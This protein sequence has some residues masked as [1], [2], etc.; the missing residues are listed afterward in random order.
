MDYEELKDGP[1]DYNA[2][3]DESI[4]ICADYLINEELEVENELLYSDNLISL[5]DIINNLNKEDI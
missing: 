2:C 5:V 4:L 1:F 3:I